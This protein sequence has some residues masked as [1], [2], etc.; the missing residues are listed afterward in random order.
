MLYSTAVQ[1][2]QSDGT[3][4]I[5]GHR[6]FTGANTAHGCS[7]AFFTSR[8]SDAVH[9]PT[10]IASLSVVGAVYLGG[11]G[12]ADAEAALWTSML[13]GNPRI[14]YWP[15]ALPANMLPTAEGWLRSQ[16]TAR[17]GHPAL[18][19]WMSLAGHHPT[20]MESFDLLF[21][22]GGNTFRLLHHIRGHDFMQAVKSFVDDGGTYY[23]GSAGAVLATDTIRIADGHDPNDLGL[24]DL[25]ALGLVHDVDL[26]PHYTEDQQAA[27]AQWAVC[28]DAI[29]LGVPNAS[30][31]LVTSEGIRV[32]GPQPVHLVTS[33][34]SQHFDAGTDIHLDC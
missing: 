15:F 4:H 26:L 31:L 27:T 12:S 17:V 5:A 16:L 2:Y 9:A 6:A 10:L 30:G 21:V 3:A 11:G 32:L 1:Q 8:R 7:S 13:H 19:T 28:H 14:L 20:E 22:G 23:G 29:V 18:E 34:G 33:R 25:G 24:T